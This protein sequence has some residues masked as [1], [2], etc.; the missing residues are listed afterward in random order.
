M[1]VTRPAT[2]CVCVC[3]QQTLTPLDH[4]FKDQQEPRDAH[5]SRGALPQMVILSQGKPFTGITECVKQK[6][7]LFLG[8]LP[9]SVVW[10]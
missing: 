1:R 4:F 8:R 3:L 6:R 9:T 7:K 5:D 2:P 10:L